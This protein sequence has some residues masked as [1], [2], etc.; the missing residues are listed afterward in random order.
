VDEK[1]SKESKLNSG[2]K[3]Y[4]VILSEPM[5]VTNELGQECYADNDFIYFYC[6]RSII[7]FGLSLMHTG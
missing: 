3:S 2:Y 5:S 1:F 7:P 4:G 6:S